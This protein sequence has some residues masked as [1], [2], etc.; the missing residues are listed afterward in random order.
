ID[1]GGFQA[2]CERLIF[3][4]GVGLPGRV[5]A[6]GQPIWI[7]DVVEDENFPRASIAA[8]EGLH[9]AFAFPILAGGRVLGVI[10]FF[11]EDVRQP[12]A[13]LLE[14]VSSIGALVG[15]F[16]ERKRA[17][18]RLRNER[19]WFRTTLASIGDGV[20][21]T[22]TQGKV[23]FLNPVAELLTGWSEREG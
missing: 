21:T 15:Q 7:P 1:G 11:R 9:A 22:D 14:M 12:D 16:L 5:W 4:P 17:D 19:E 18:E 2:A 20:I 6:S 23:T 13:D 10:E 8:Q 3:Q